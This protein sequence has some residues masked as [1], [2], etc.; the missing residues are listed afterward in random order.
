LPGNGSLVAALAT[1]LGRQPDVVVG[2]P[3]P[4]LFASAAGRVGAHRPLVVGDRLD[5]DIGGA[6]QAGFDGM[7]VLTGVSTAADVLAA[8]AGARPTWIA[9]DLNALADGGAAA[10]VPTVSSGDES[11]ECGGWTVRRA[12][13]GLE[14]SGEGTDVAALAALAAMAWQR[15]PP[16]S[17]IATGAMAATT[18]QLLG[19]AG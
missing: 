17:V 10:R 16:P 19:I 5:T 8:P 12:D 6:V 4:T 7:I 15:P 3:S 9:R 1:A 2:K 18:V 14:L 11:A 13:V